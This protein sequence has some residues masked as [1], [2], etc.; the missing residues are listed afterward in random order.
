MVFNLLYMHCLCVE[1]EKLSIIFKI[2]GARFIR[3]PIFYRSA[4]VVLLTG[5]AAA[6]GTE[7]YGFKSHQGERF[8]GALY[9][10]RLESVT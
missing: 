7:V 8:L 4:L 6:S 3:R 9:M 1:I 10:A 5:I 2:F